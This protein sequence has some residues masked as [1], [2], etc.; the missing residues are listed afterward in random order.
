MNTTREPMPTWVIPFEKYSSTCIFN[1]P[2]KP[3]MPVYKLINT[4]KFLTVFVIFGLM[5]FYNNFSQGAWVYMA[6]QG[7]YGYCWVIKDFGFRDPVTQTPTTW[8]GVIATSIAIG[9][10][11]LILAWLVIALH[12][13]HTGFQLFVGVALQMLG[14]CIMIAGDCQRHF[15]LKYKKGLIT[16]GMFRYTRNP[17]YFGET[18]IYASFAWMTAHW[19]GALLLAYWVLVV[20]TPRFYR[21]DQSISRHPGWEEYKATSSMLIPW[22]WFNG[23]AIKDLWEPAQS[24]SQ[25]PSET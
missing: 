16:T 18:L 3:L 21:K 12:V 15:T 22:A 9:I 20:F 1:P 5:S 8:F 7:I 14:I 25:A 2:G 24:T 6:L 19:L 11:S 4:Y 17:N 13:E 10:P 23:R